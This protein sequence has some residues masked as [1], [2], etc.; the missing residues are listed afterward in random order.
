[1]SLQRKLSFTGL[2]FLALT[3]IQ[4]GSEGGGEADVIYQGTAT[5]EAYVSFVDAEARITVNDAK[6][7]SVTMPTEGQMYQPGDAPPPF[8]WTEGLSAS[9]E[10]VPLPAR[11]GAARPATLMDLL[12]PGERAAFAHLPPVTGKVYL[13]RFSIPGRSTQL[14]VL[15]T[16]TDYTPDA[17]AWDSI[18]GASGPISLEIVAAY[19]RDNRIEE[20][21]FKAAATRSF[22]IADNFW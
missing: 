4:C 19:L 2:G 9:L 1:M 6:A 5:D 10:R 20:G 18:K 14:L 16:N 12:L 3:L 11:R 13:A 22:S 8:R 7:P 15:T 21:P 17:A